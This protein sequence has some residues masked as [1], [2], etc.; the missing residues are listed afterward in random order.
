LNFKNKTYQLP[1][2]KNLVKTNLLKKTLFLFLVLIVALPSFAQK[3]K[4]LENQRKKLIQEIRVTTNLL[5]K[6][7]KT[8]KATL[9][10][11]LTLQKQIKKRQKLIQTLN[12]EI[13]FTNKSINRSVDVVGFLEDDVA[14]LKEEYSEM[15]RMAYRQKLNKSH[16]LFIFSSGSF[17]EA[18]RRWQ[19]L[20]QYDGYRQKQSRLILET[21]NTLN[22]KVV[23]L[24][25]RK[26][27]KQKLL[28][29]EERQAKLL[30][31]ERVAKDELLEKLKGDESRLT[32]DL[33]AKEKAKE[34]LNVAIEN[35]IRDEMARRRREERNSAT[36]G[37][38]NSSKK[39]DRT[40]A[41]NA[42]TK[43]FLQL[44]GRMPWPVSKGV[45][46][47]YFG[48]QAHPT[49]KTIEIT[50]NGIDIQTDANAEVRA[51][52]RG[53]VIGK[54]FIPGHDY[55]VI[56]QHG[57]Y[58]T[59]YSHLEE[60]FVQKGETVKGRQVIGKVS[61]D[62]TTRSSEVHFEVWKEKVRLNPTHWVRR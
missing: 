59:V 4:K 53:K 47:S 35:I 52:H 41:E 25:E 1:F 49:I 51:I 46:T 15:L 33:R 36:A 18:F 26:V 11:F 32:G 12:E 31:A 10:R 50:N 39:S 13:N 57:N 23:S 55:M 6:T 5:Q 44:K 56:L 45:I 58:Y 16:L 24:E 37:N 21:Q 28:K 19:Y 30:R 3:R 40:V 17:N 9:E 34:K 27:E 14:R 20:K 2:F 38:S 48:K 29:S 8:K 54:Q 62:G 43:G 22:T 42:V 61:T 7:K 60:V